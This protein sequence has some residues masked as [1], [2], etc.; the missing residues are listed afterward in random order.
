VHET[1]GPLAQL[2]VH[3]V[4][5][6]QHLGTFDVDVET[7]GVRLGLF[8][9]FFQLPFGLLELQLVDVVGRLGVPR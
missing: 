1:V 7:Q 8:L 5:V 4:L 3:L 9:P 6:P 2:P